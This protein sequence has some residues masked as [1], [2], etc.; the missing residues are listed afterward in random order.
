MKLPCKGTGIAL[1]FKE[2]SIFEYFIFLGKRSI[3]PGR[4]KWTIP[5][6]GFEIR[7]DED[8]SC[9]AE[10]EFWKETEIVF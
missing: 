1:F 7:R 5:G 10:R 9:T 2:N 3:K 8:L 6:G 4:G